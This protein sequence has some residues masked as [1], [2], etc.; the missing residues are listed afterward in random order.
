MVYGCGRETRGS[1]SERRCLVLRHRRRYEIGVRGFGMPSGGRASVH[2]TV[3]RAFHVAVD[4]GGQLERAGAQGRDA[5]ARLDGNSDGGRD[6]QRMR[7]G[8]H[9]ASGAKIGAVER[10]LR[11]RRERDTAKAD[12]GGIANRE[13][14]N[15]IAR[16]RAERST[17]ACH[18]LLRDGDSELHVGAASLN[19][20]PVCD[21]G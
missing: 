5:P 21:S 7:S 16:C 15:R 4:H 3:S 11:P 17:G 18:R 10:Q 9:V 2:L 13:C 6:Y 1:D 19:E 12:R 14:R 8:L 20:T